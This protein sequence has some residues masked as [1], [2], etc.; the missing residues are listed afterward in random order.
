VH[1]TSL[2]ARNF[3]NLTLIAD[4]SSGEKKCS[5]PQEAIG[6]HPRMRI[7]PA[8]TYMGI[9]ELAICSGKGGA[10]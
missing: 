6:F 4:S 3:A 7:I 10:F 5:A 8:R 1:F 9:A 2:I